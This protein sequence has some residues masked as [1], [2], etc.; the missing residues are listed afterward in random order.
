MSPSPEVVVMA[1]WAQVIRRRLQGSPP[2]GDLI[3]PGQTRETAEVN[4]VPRGNR[5]HS[6]ARQL[7][8]EPA[9]IAETIQSKSHYPSG[10]EKEHETKPY[11]FGIS[12]SRLRLLGQGTPRRGC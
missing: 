2:R 8:A 7:R 10:Q 11:V 5:P 4:P 6:G 1:S 3:E 12:N 9:R